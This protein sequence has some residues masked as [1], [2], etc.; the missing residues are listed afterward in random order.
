MM[1]RGGGVL[2][3]CIAWCLRWALPE[4][5]D[6]SAIVRLHWSMGAARDSDPEVLVSGWWKRHHSHCS[7]PAKG[8]MPYMER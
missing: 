5:G 3:A 7:Q 6:E 2:Y 1:A 4:T 8:D